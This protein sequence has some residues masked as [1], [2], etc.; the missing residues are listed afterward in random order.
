MTAKK[1]YNSS[2]IIELNALWYVGFQPLFFLSYYLLEFYIN[3]F[4]QKTYNSRLKERYRD[5]PSTHLDIDPELWL[6]AGLSGGLDRNQVYRL[7]NTIAEN[8]WMT[9]SVSTIG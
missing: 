2:W 3:F 9:H 1:R 8:L 7:S 6:E 4:F 5:N